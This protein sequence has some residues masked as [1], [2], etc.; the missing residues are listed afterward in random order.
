[1]EVV[2]ADALDVEVE[3]AVEIT[4]LATFHRNSKDE[5]DFPCLPPA[6]VPVVPVVF[7]VPPDPEPD[8][9]AEVVGAAVE[10]GV[11][12]AE[13]RQS[14]WQFSYARFSAAVPFPWKQLEMHSIVAF[15]WE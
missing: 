10:A 4:Q 12:V 3:T 7:A 11:M 5:T 9:V 6:S 2:D 14:F 8:W 1:L 15:C 13:A